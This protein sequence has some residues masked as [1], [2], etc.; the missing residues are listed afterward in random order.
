MKQNINPIFGVVL[1]GIVVAAALYFGIRSTGPAAK[2]HEPVDMGKF[3]GKAQIAPP[4][5][6]MP[7]MHGG[8]PG[9][10]GR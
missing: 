9:Q 5:R 3:M 10:P 6:G 2:S 4:S 1:V 7:G 8:P